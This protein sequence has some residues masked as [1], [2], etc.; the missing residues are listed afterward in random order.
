M[1]GNKKKKLFVLDTNVILHDSSCIYKFEE[2]DVV[3]P[4][5]VIEELDNFK[6]GFETVNF[7]SREFCRILDELSGGHIFNGGVQLG[8]GLGKLRIELV[9]GLQQGIK[10]NLRTINVDAEIINLAFYLKTKDENKN[11]EVVIVSKDTNLRMKAK[12]LGVL[13]QDF[14]T[15]TV[16]NVDFLTETVQEVV[17]SE[18]VIKN[19]FTNVI[20][21]YE[22]KN[23]LQNQHF[24]I[25]D[26]NKQIGLVRYYDKKIKK[27]Q[28]DTLS[29]FGIKPKNSEQAFGMD[30]LLDPKITL[31]TIEGKAGTGKN[32]ISIASG[33]EQ[34]KKEL[35][36]NFMFTRQTV[37]M[38][39]REIGFLPDDV[40][41]KIGPFMKGM[42]DNLEVLGKINGN[43]DRISNFKTSNKIIIEPLAFIRGRSLPNSF[44]V[45]DEAQNLTPHEVKTIVT[46]AGEG[47]KIVFIGDT[48]QIDNPYLDE[49]S[50]GFSYLIERFKGQDCY[51]HVHLVKSERSALADLAGELL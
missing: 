4:I 49:R 28:K 50:N 17:L 20:V 11:R 10:E 24:I 51:S 2:N 19:L 5:Q 8:E 47:T 45:I 13:A 37:S 32:F 34:L 48:R 25:S 12:A 7:H 26:G 6:K 3:V 44:F 40:N 18:S 35:Y 38:G 16:S 43:S 23:A 29:A 33:L 27:I 1:S 14:L 30:A 31:V 42:N 9:A 15:E 41:D 21:E 46:R 36:H 39:D 22:I